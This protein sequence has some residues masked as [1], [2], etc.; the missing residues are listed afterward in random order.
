MRAPWGKIL[1]DMGAIDQ[2]VLAKALGEQ[3]AEGGRTLVGEVLVRHGWADRQA[4]QTAVEQQA[5]ECT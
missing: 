3:L 5:L 4:V 1:L 2:E